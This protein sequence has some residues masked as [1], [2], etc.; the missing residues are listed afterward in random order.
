MAHLS[1][2]AEH[3]HADNSILEICIAGFYEVEIQVLLRATTPSMSNPDTCRQHHHLPHVA[4]VTWNGCQVRRA[5][6]RFHQ[7]VKMSPITVFDQT[8]CD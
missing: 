3:V 6:L 7:I 2:I 4:D 1:V 8:A 5:L